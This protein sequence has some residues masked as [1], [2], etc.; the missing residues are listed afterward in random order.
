MKNFTS[1]VCLDGDLFSSSPNPV[2]GFDEGQGR[3][4]IG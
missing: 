4:G 1:S 3:A 2:S